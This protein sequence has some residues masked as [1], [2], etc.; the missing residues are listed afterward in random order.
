MTEFF[1]RAPSLSCSPALW[2]ACPASHCSHARYFRPAPWCLLSVGYWWH[3][4]WL[5]GLYLSAALA[6]VSAG[7]HPWSAASF[8][9]CPGYRQY[10]LCLCHPF[11]P[12]EWWTSLP[13]PAGSRAAEFFARNWPEGQLSIPGFSLRK[14]PASWPLRIGPCSCPSPWRST[15]YPLWS[16]PGWFPSFRA[17]LLSPFAIGSEWRTEFLSGFA[18]SPQVWPAALA[19]SSLLCSI[20][21]PEIQFCSAFRSSLT[22]SG[23][24]SVFG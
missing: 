3:Q 9:A 2:R 8:Q 12:V 22:K 24:A 1:L 21:F 4:F 5:P 16:Y 14:H 17:A 7:S 6:Q 20:C 10:R 18:H 13:K 19:Y 11:G 15:E 23:P